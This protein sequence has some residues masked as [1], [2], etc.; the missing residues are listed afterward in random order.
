VRRP[1]RCSISAAGR[2][3][4]Q[5]PSPRG[6]TVGDGLEGAAQSSPGDGAAAHSGC[7]GWQAGFPS[8]RLPAGRFDGVFA[9]ASRVPQLRAGRGRSPGRLNHAC[10]KPAV[11]SLRTSDGDKRKDGAA[12]ATESTTIRKLGEVP[13]QRRDS[14]KLTRIYRPAGLAARTAAM[15]RERVRNKPAGTKAE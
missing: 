2:A 1:S 8:A 3:G 10:S 13:V 5:G 4:P 14:S 12:D 15:A 7:E 6:G 9:N 11:R